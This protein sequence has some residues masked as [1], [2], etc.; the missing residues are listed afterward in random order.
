MMKN[1]ARR[2]KKP[3]SEPNQQVHLCLFSYNHK[4]RLYGTI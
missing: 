4:G 1:L 2:E 3:L